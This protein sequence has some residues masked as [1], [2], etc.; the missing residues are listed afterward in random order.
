MPAHVHAGAAHLVGELQ[1]GDA[2]EG[3]A[4]APG[5]DEAVFGV[6]AQHGPE[7][8]TVLEDFVA[9]SSLERLPA[10]A[11]SRHRPAHS[12]PP[13]RVE[14]ADAVRVD[15]VPAQVPV[16]RL[17]EVVARRVLRRRL[18]RA[19]R[20]ARAAVRAPRPRSGPLAVCLIR[21]ARRRGGARAGPV[22]EADRLPL[23]AVPRGRRRRERVRRAPAR[24]RPREGGLCLHH[25][26]G[27]ARAPPSGPGPPQPLF[28]PVKPRDDLP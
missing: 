24:A 11:G 8:E 13:H 14:V 17:E 4:H 23:P 7:V 22:C 12:R 2:R 5:R 25:A 20:R 3:C 21:G 1:L 15:A 27:V 19:V 16:V 10:R 18:P 26:R 9:H 28:R 6:V